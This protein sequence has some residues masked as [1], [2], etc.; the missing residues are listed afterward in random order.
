[1]PDGGKFDP[2][3]YAASYPDVVAALGTNEKVL[4]QHYLTSGKNEGRL[5]YAPGA[6]KAAPKNLLDC[7]VTD[8]SGFYFK[9]DETD[10]YG[11]RY[12]DKHLNTY[13]NHKARM[14]VFAETS[15]HQYLSGTI[16]PNVDVSN[17][18]AFKVT[19]YANNDLVYTSPIIEHYTKPVNFDVAINHPSHVK[20]EVVANEYSTLNDL[21]IANT[22][23]HD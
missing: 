6:V 15:S 1:M 12:F 8:K 2:T 18:I 7:L 10:S 19:I 16:A 3:F 11:N 5:P 21:I 14:I 20:I 17:N 13:V 9:T 22:T 23:L 4:Y